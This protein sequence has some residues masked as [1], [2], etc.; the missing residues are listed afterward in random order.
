MSNQQK[1]IV[2]LTSFPAAMPFAVQAI[3]SV[4]DGSVLPDKIVL[5]LTAS[6]FPNEEIPEDLQ[7]LVNKNSIFEVRF[8]EENIR[9]YT[10]LVP[11]LKDFPNDI[12]VTVDDDIFYGKNMLKG[13]LRLHK[14][15]PD[16]VIG[17]RIRHLK[18]NAPY[19]K[20]KRYKEHRYL[21][22]SLKPKYGNVQTGVGGVLYPPHSLCPEML[23]SKIFMDMAPTVDDIWFWAAVVANGTKIAPV[24]FGDAKLN[25]LRKPTEISLLNTNIK[26]GNDVNRNVLEKILEKYPVIKQRVENEVEEQSKK[27]AFKQFKRLA[28]RLKIKRYEQK[29]N[30]KPFGDI[31]SEIQ[32]AILKRKGIYFRDENASK[33]LA[34]R[35]DGLMKKPENLRFIENAVPVVMCAN[36]NFAP[37]LAV[38][39]QSLLEKSNPQ[40]EYHFMVFESN[41]SQKSK[42]CLIAQADKF[43]HCNIDIINVKSALNSIPLRA[44]NHVSIDAFSRLFIPYWL[45]KYEKVIY[46][47]CDMIAK[48]DIAEL[49]DLD[50]ENFC[51]GICSSNKASKSVEQK[52]YG[53]FMKRTSAFALLDDWSRYISSGVLVFDVKK[54]A[55]KFPY[56]DLFR[57]A[58]YF[59][60]RYAVRLNDQDVLTLLVKDNYFALPPEWNYSWSEKAGKGK[61][62]PAKTGTKIIHFTG[63]LKPWKRNSLIDDNSDVQDYREVAANV[64]LFRDSVKL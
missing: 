42:E 33:Q 56:Q 9:S 44:V 1:I 14:Q 16:A 21:L 61:Y 6:Q 4:L 27:C 41:L 17:H 43:T 20:W 57:F 45:D 7:A 37:Y 35:W 40:R 25:D 55:E 51:I 47:D 39:L 8:Y 63:K 54:F 48:A 24:P 60:N 26:S 31:R 29:F 32:D 58:I 52:K 12:I 59:T 23:D 10:K 36:E 53:Y 15:Y 46:L 11:A 34:E 38:M 22:K 64:P 5:Y 28:W 49:Y 2:S 50:L 18:L 13:L 19:R 30:G 3:Q 62:P